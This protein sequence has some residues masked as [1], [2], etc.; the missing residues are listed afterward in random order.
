[1]QGEGKVCR[2]I[3]G[4]GYYARVH[5]FYADDLVEQPRVCF[6]QGMVPRF[7]EAYEWGYAAV[8]GAR[9]ALTM[10]KAPGR[11]TLLL[12][13]GHEPDTTPMLVAIAAFRAVWAALGVQPDKTAADTLHVLETKANLADPADLG[14]LLGQ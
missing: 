3:G 13:H 5:V 9:L 8:V 1:M 14:G 10:S 11:C 12:L 4:R 6:A 7:D 2:Q